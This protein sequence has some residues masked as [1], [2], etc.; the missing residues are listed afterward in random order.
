MQNNWPNPAIFAWLRQILSDRYGHDFYIK[1]VDTRFVSMVLPNSA[2]TILLTVDPVAFNRVDSDLPFSSWD[3]V[4]EGWISVLGK[5]LPAPGAEVLPVPLIE[6]TEMGYCIHYDVLGLTYWMLSRLEEINPKNL[7]EYARFPASCSH[8]FKYGYLE[9]PV[10]DAWLHVLG[11]V[12]Q[13]VWPTLEFKQHQFSMVVSHDVDAPS[14]YGFRTVKGIVRAMAGDLL[15]RQDL[16]SAV[17]GPWIHLNSKE[18]L[19]PADPANSFNWIMDVSERRGLVSAFYFICGRTNPDYDSDYEPEHPTIR[20]LMQRIHA[21]GHEI[22]LHPSYGTYRAPEIL[23]AEAERLRHVCQQIGITLSIFGGRMH[24]LRWEHPITMRGLTLAGMAYDNTLTYAN[25]AGFRCG[26]CFE[27]PAFDPLEGKQLSL[28]I[29]PLVAMETTIMASQHMGL[30]TGKSALDKFC[31]LKHTC[32]LLGG[33][34]TL[35]W[36]NTQFDSKEKRELYQAVL[37]C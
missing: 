27:Y 36:H 20:D 1:P 13:R 24:Y 14:R 10:V 8:A 23:I 25:H 15:K 7:D 28:R 37:D 26:T 6:Q 34:F 21:R 17:L 29:R 35:L 22:G 4:A 3:A 33:C 16:K 9:Y 11:Q 30:G 32:K 19:H 18:R 12:I 5:L 2:A 31:E